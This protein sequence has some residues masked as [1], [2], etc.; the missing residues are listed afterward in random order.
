MRRFK[1]LAAL[2]AIGGAN[3]LI[4]PPLSS[5]GSSKIIKKRAPAVRA[6]VPIDQL[7]EALITSKAFEDL[8]ERLEEQTHRD[9]DIIDAVQ[10]KFR[11][12]PAKVPP[13]D[14][15]AS[16]GVAA[17]GADRTSAVASAV[18][19][20]STAAA[21]EPAAKLPSQQETKSATAAPGSPAAATSTSAASDASGVPAA[22]AAPE[23]PTSNL[24]GLGRDGKESS[25][26]KQKSEIKTAIPGGQEER[27]VRDM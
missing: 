23:P 15:P 11:F 4:S 27:Q 20:T 21:S 25:P 18:T 12:E 8:V 2:L 5:G 24:F 7:R 22:Q 16:I 6:R 14:P 19:T 1:F 9:A 10:A 26:P 13:N 17:A 3:A